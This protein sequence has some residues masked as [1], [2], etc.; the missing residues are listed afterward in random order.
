MI[1]NNFFHHLEKEFKVQ[2]EN[3]WHENSQGTFKETEDRVKNFLRN[4]RAHI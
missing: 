3:Y 4:T 2:V 1:L